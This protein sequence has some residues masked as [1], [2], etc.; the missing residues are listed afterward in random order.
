MR[1]LRNKWYKITVQKLEPNGFDEEEFELYQTLKAKT[2]QEALRIAKRK[3]FTW[4][5]DRY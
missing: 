3:M 5:V 2:P 4:R 1:K